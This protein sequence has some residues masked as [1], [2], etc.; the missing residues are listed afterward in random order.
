MEQ[1]TWRSIPSTHPM[2]R[3]RATTIS[4]VSPRGALDVER[5]PVPDIVVLCDGCNQNQYPNSVDAVFIDGQLYDVFCTSCRVRY[6]PGAK[7]G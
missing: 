7:E 6:F 3:D 1:V 2:F 5:I 4:S